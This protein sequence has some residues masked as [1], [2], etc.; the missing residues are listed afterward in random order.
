MQLKLRVPHTLV[1]MF[2]MMVVALVLTWLLPAGSFD[3]EPG[4]GGREVVVPGTYATLPD[5]SPLPPWALLTVVP[6][7]M[8]DAQAVIFF[9]LIIGG[10]IAVLRAT[11]AL[12]AL[13]GRVL[14]RFGDQLAPLIFAAMFLFGLFSASFG[15]ASEYI[16]FVGILLAFAVALRLDNMAAVAIIV[17]GYGIGYGVALFNPFTVLI[18]QEIAGLPPGSGAA[19]RAVV[20]V[21]VFVVG[22][23]HVLRYARRVQTDP[24]SSL[25][26]DVPAAAPVPVQ[27]YPDLSARHVIVLLLCGATLVALITGIWLGGWFLT[28]IAAL[29]LGLA[30]ASAVVARL[31]WD[32]TADIFVAGAAQM[33]G[34]ALL[35]GFARSIALLLEDGQVLHTVVNGVATPLAALPAE[36]SAVG[37]LLIQSLMN[38]FIPSGSGQAFATMPIMAPIG[39][40]VGISRQVTVLAYQFG[41]GFTNMIVPTN[42]VLMGILGIAGI[43]YDR[44]LRFIMPL[45]LKLLL[46]CA[47]A[48][49]VAVRIGVS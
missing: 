16:A 1:L 41:D 31:P 19:F 42:P 34:T 13:M 46:V 17:V 43:P 18:A 47:L 49:V 44:W 28:E 38:F 33:A 11:G 45:M 29:F 10:V 6:R 35:I 3:T 7:A 21:P 5:V 14:E 37:M 25:V 15:M 23:L 40:L 8:A 24:A 32:R 30:I 20:I 9:V 12:D 4:A 22:Y 39:D 48:L 36:L 27:E 2:A 26:A